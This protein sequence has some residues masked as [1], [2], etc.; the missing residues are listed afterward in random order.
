LTKK[1]TE[2]KPAPAAKPVAALPIKL[3]ISAP[4]KL[5]DEA[6]KGKMTFEEFRR[7]ASV[8]T[9]RFADRRP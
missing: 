6:G 1:G 3:I 2:A 9:L 4:K 8:E 5:L 7:R